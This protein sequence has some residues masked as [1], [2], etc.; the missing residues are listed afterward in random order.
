MLSNTINALDQITGHPENRFPPLFGTILLLA[1]CRCAT[2]TPVYRHPPSRQNTLFC[3]SVYLCVK[4]PAP[5][6]YIT[7]LIINYPVGLISMLGSDTAGMDFER[8]VASSKEVKT[9]ERWMN[10][11][12]R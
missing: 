5:Q 7:N 2:L 3:A 12:R 4:I 10:W 9:A 6:F 8:R 11:R 1:L